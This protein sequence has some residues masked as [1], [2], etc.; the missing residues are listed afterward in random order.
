MKI[1]IFASALLALAWST[2]CTNLDENLYSQVGSDDYGKTPSEIETIVGRAYSA[3]RGFNDKTSISYPT[4]EYVFFLNACVSDEACIP[5]R[6]TDW[7]DGGRYQEA[8]YHTWT[9]DNSM[10]LSAWRYHF[11]G[12]AKINAVIY[13][14]DKSLLEEE[15]KLIIK[16]ELRGLRAYFYYNLLDLF[17]NVPIVTNYE[18]LELPANSTRKEVFEFVEKELTETLP[19]LPTGK[20]YGRVTQNVAN[21]LLARLYLNSEVF[22]GIARWQECLDACDRITGYALEPN[23]FANFA[24][25]NES[26]EENIFV[27]PYDHKAGTTGNYLHS[28]TFHYKQK[29]AF[30]PKA[31]YPWCGNGICG[32]PG[33]YSSF[34]EGDARKKAMLAGEQTDLATGNVILMDDGNK[35]DYTE[36]IIDY[37]HAVQNEGVRLF[38][39]EVKAGETWERDHD[40]VLIRYAEIVMMKAECLVHQGNPEAAQPLVAEIRTRAGL[41]T[42]APVDLAFIDQERKR[43]FVFEGLRRTDNIR[44]GDFFKPWWIKGETPAYRALFPIPQ[45]ELDKN[46]HLTQNPGY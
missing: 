1:K 36:A 24:T 43:E 20:I 33:L 10:I 44:S 18:D 23:Y 14:V 12:I 46:I 31:D 34:D 2:S 8:E 28:M 9:P 26:S 45:S 15:A 42:P 11:E 27:I 16:A 40:W 5:T 37:Q 19:L 7:F 17:G 25:N 21:A 30:S 6:G 32:Q 4:C 39:Y 13:Q 41:D 29:F 3:L 38:K 35:L 22:T